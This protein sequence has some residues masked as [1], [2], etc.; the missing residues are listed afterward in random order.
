MP[1]REP[2]RWPKRLLW[3]QNGQRGQRTGTAALGRTW[4]L[5]SKCSWNGSDKNRDF[6]FYEQLLCS[7]ASL[8]GH[9][10][11]ILRTRLG[12]SMPGVHRVRSENQPCLPSAHSLAPP[13]GP[14]LLLRPRLSCPAERGVSGDGTRLWHVRS[15][16][17]TPGQPAGTRAPQTVCGSSGHVGP[18]IRLEAASEETLVQGEDGASVW[19]AHASLWRGREREEEKGQSAGWTGVRQGFWN[20][21]HGRL[22]D[23][24]R[25]RRPQTP[26]PRRLHWEGRERGQAR[27]R[28]AAADP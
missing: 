9:L 5:A 19:K 7:V 26:G 4:S 17:R 13:R 8:P 11:P 25:G 21:P 27:G 20:F 10:E 23:R 16:P 3:G 12:Q 2:R 24:G 28:A 6:A 14:V 22:W 15:Q 18:G 1:P